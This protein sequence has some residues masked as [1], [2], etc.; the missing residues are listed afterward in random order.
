[1]RW[2]GQKVEKIRNSL[3]MEL[4]RLSQMSFSC[5]Q[6]KDH[7]VKN[8]THQVR[9]VIKASCLI[10]RIKLEH[11]EAKRNL[12]ITEMCSTRRLYG[13]F[14]SESGWALAFI[15]SENTQWILLASQASY[16]RYLNN[17]YIPFSLHCSIFKP[18]S[19]DSFAMANCIPVC[20]LR[21]TKDNEGKR[22]LPDTL[23]R[24]RKH[25]SAAIF[26]WDIVYFS[27]R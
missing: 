26:L 20:Q 16:K 7:T 5:L 8:K 22:T 3:T 10:R 1:M 21:P 18:F 24:V 11:L 23:Q 25:T 6:S 27:L 15:T 14:F 9:N 19:Y 17:I 13:C 12:N 2:G 4:N